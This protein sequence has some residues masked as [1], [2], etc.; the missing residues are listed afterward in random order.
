MFT[1]INL[2]YDYA[3]LE[4]YIDEATMRLH[5]G[6][7][8]AGYVDN[9]NKTLEPYP[10]FQDL[11][12]EALLSDLTKVP[13]E[14]RVKV[15]NF[16]GGVANH[17]LYWQIMAPNAQGKT[18]QPQGKLLATLEQTFGGWQVFQEKFTAAGL[19]H[20]GSGWAWLSMAEGKLVIETTANQ[21]SPLSISHTPILALDVWEHAYYL[22][23]R[24]LR[25]EYIKNWWQV[26][27]WGEVEKRFGL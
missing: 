5:H 12:V 19:G 18:N 21:D 9:L 4:P 23:Y 13:E 20:F 8:H 14:I 10:Q 22:K 1:L 11:T 16:G 6:K 24:N 27:N 15:K 17:N 2:P 7:H 25:A 3:A 26:V